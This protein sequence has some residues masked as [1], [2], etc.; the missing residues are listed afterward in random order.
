MIRSGVG[1]YLEF[2]N[3]SDNFFFSAEAKKFVRIPFSKSEIFLNQHLTLK[4]KRQL[5]KVIELCLRGYDKLSEKEITSKIINSTHVYEKLDIELTPAEFQQLYEHKDR[6]VAE[7]LRTLGIEGQ[8]KAILLYAI[9]FFTSSQECTGEN[10]DAVTT[11]QF[12]E[13][14]QRYLRSI[15]LYGDSPLLTCVYGSSE[16]AQ[17]FSRV[18]SLFQSTYI[19]NP[20]V[21]LAKMNFSMNERAEFE[22]LEF[23]FNDTPLTCAKGVIVGA[24][25]QNWVLKEAG[26][27]CK[28][29]RGVTCARLTLIAKRPLSGDTEK[30]GT[31]IFPPEAIDGNRHPIRVFQ[32]DYLAAACPRECYLIMASM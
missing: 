28:Q 18:G 3:I 4:E 30:I 15:G 9:G 2:Q 7:F 25:Y 23:N 6:P 29:E 5:V 12:F 11:F 21:K 17:A 8:L 16:Y 27:S 1:N 26:I 14:V 19:V 32:F 10:P 13:R 22:S 24:D 20:D 31:F